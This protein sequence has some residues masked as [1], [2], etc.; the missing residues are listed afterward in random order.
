MSEA[1]VA[2]IAVC[3]ATYWLDKPYDYLIPEALLG[4]VKPGVRVTVPFSRGNRRSEGIVLGVSDRSDFDKLKPIESVLDNDPVLT[5]SQIR[6]AL[7]MHDRFFCTVYDAVKTILPAGFWFKSDGTRRVNDKTS[8]MISLAVGAEEAF[9]LSQAK[10]R[11]APMQAELLALLCSV[12]R[13]SAQEALYFTGASRQSLKALVN[14]GLVQTD[15]EEVFRRPEIWTD[16]IQALPVLN[17][18]QSAVYEGLN[19]LLS[20]SSAEAA[21]LCG[22]TGSGKTSVYIHLIDDVLKAGKSAILLVPEISLTPQMIRTFSGYFGNQVA[23]LHSSLSLG[24]RYDEWKRAKYGDA[25]LVIG[26]RS[27]V[28][29]PFENLGLI[30]ID[31]EQEESYKSENS[32]RYH[33]RDIA[34]YR[35][36]KTDSLLLLGSATPDIESRYAAETGKYKY[37]EL[38]ARYNEMQL[39]AVRIVD[40]KSELRSGNGGNISARLQN[41]LEE[42]LVR[43]EQSILFINRRGANKLISCGECGHIYKCPNC[44]VSLTY[45][46]SNR[47]LMCHYCG[48]S[49]KPDPFCPDCGGLLTFIGAGTQLVEEELKQLFP[50]A[51]VIRM[52]TDT[53]K[54]AGSHEAL[55]EKF[56]EEKIPIMVGTQMVT[57]GLNFENVTLIGVLSADQ[58]LYCGDYRSGERTFSLITQVVGRSGR[59]KKP[60]RAVIQTFTPQNEIIRLA[61]A[62]DYDGFYRSEIQLRRLQHT[63]PFADII[64]ITASG[65]EESAVLKCCSDIRRILAASVR[66]RPDVSILGPAPL[67]VVKVNNRYRYRVNLSCRADKEIRELVSAVLIKLNS[68]GKYKGVSI[69]A[70]NNPLS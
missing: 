69:F 27:A 49:R 63:P 60:G 14:A 52:D 48:Y 33:A 47:R 42:N 29:A 15:F 3:A 67:A 19:E 32:P 43:G 5:P 6:L 18:A 8:E 1:T 40:M 4:K 53:V 10:R 62:Q 38:N 61:A 45:H 17:S 37:F 55:L 20:E 16:D 54:A 26:T 7:W 51:G 65:A 50:D 46:S 12:G 64:S 59:G 24:E 44:S 13:V 68:S 28:F 66:S 57:K 2:K 39:P 36:A 22:V 34:K 70:D 56:R 23:V 30:I 11:K 41:E 25:R 21:L 9:A 31:E 35:C 58:S